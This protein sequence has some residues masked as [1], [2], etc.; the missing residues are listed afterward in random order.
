MDQSRFCEIKGALQNIATS[1]FSPYARKKIRHLFA[2]VHE[3]KLFFLVSSISIFS[4]LFYFSRFP[5]GCPS[6][7]FS[8]W[9]IVGHLT[10]ERRKE[11]KRNGYQ[12]KRRRLGFTV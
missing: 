1:P 10:R 2:N 5:V 7:F 8:S 3:L 12:E 6:I 11:K 9:S 4:L